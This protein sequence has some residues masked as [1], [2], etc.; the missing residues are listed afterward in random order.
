MTNVRQFISLVYLIALI[1]AFPLSSDAKRDYTDDALRHVDYYDCAHAGF[2]LDSLLYYY[3]KPHD[4]EEDDIIEEIIIDAYS[5]LGMYKKIIDR[6][7]RLE[8]N[9]NYYYKDQF[10][11]TDY[12][13]DAYK[14]LG[15]YKEAIPYYNQELRNTT[16]NIPDLRRYPLA[17]NIVECYDKGGLAKD[18][19]YYKCQ[20]IV[21]KDAPKPL[22][23]SR[24]SV[25]GK[26]TISYYSQR[27]HFVPVDP[28]TVAS[29]YYKSASEAHESLTKEDYYYKPIYLPPIIEL[30]DYLLQS[31]DFRAAQKQSDDVAQLI[32]SYWGV[33]DANAAAYMHRLLHGDLKRAY[34]M[35]YPLTLHYIVRQRIAATLS[36]RNKVQ[37]YDAILQELL[38]MEAPRSGK[39]VMVYD[40]IAH[41]QAPLETNT[42]TPAFYVQ[43]LR[44]MK[45]ANDAYIAYK[46]H[47]LPRLR[48]TLHQARMEY[49]NFYI[50]QLCQPQINATEKT[51]NTFT[52]LTRQYIHAV[53]NRLGHDLYSYAFLTQDKQIANEAYLYTLFNKQLLLTSDTLL[54]AAHSREQKVLAQKRKNLYLQL[55]QSASL[56]KRD[57]ILDQITIVERQLTMSHVGDSTKIKQL[58][59]VNTKDVSRQ[60]NS[61]ELALEFIRYAVCRDWVDSSSKI[62]AFV[63][64]SNST[65]AEFV[66]IW[67]EQSLLLKGEPNKKN[68]NAQYTYTY[69]T[70]DFT[71][72]L[73]PYITNIKTLYFSP[74]GALNQVA[75]ENCMFNAQERFADRYQCVRLSSTKEIANYKR[76]NQTALSKG[77]AV[78]YG[79]INYGTAQAQYASTRTMRNMIEP[80]AFSKQEI[81]GIEKELKKHSIAT[82]CLSRQ[83]GTEESVWTLDNTSPAILHFSTHSFS[84]SNDDALAMPYYKRKQ[85]PYILPMERCGLMLANAAPTLSG[86]TRVQSNDGILT[87]MEIAML[88]LH[89]TK[90]AVLSA[91]ETALGDITSEGVWGLQRAFKMAGVQTIVMS[92]WQ[93]DDEATSI[94]MQYFYEELFRQPQSRFSPHAALASAQR[95][96][97]QHP[98][99]SSPYY[100]AAFIAID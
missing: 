65:Q 63:I 39:G 48:E 67:D 1:L 32:R 15:K 89:D 41:A 85:T 86:T 19:L 75:I 17:R 50:R 38:S 3:S 84:L 18:Q 69:I 7:K 74:D 87:A 62:G 53:Y 9:R 35:Y 4:H 88:D 46:Q 45:F 37:V 57:S 12:M 66:S 82:T 72:A 34:P 33:T 23:P 16:D 31:G 2:S 98:Q 5:N 60:L 28:T 29:Q 10:L 83:R 25:W 14:A 55:G 30:A 97:R 42:N 27:K 77:S 73:K 58:L 49:Q 56:W 76:R 44:S 11:F 90:L 81:A 79:D 100:W 93:V 68:I 51:D 6:C 54:Y 91:C 24:R 52:S 43:E 13:A 20:A 8:K 78:L 59:N 80:L 26:D 21:V 96:M 36:E 61:T 47:R 70:N 71:N 92:L 22:A 64:T 95:R 40:A 94:L 99:Y